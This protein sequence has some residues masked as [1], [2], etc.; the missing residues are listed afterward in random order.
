MIVLQESGSAQNINFIPRE[1]TANASY[2]VKIK[3]ETQNKE[4]YS[5]A[6]TG[7]SQNLYY[8]RFNAVFPVKQDIYYMLTILS[9]TTEIFKDK[10]YCTNQ[11]NLPEYTINS[12]E[13][14]SND[15]TNEFITL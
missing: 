7:I 8:N 6:T 12:G 1:F 4:V 5:Q 15:T 9:G 14:T 2:T 10:I 11:T 13:Y 3:D